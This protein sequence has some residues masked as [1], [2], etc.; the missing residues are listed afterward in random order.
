MTRKNNASLLI[1]VLSMAC[2][3]CASQPAASSAKA[4]KTA[5][6]APLW[7]TDTQ[8][9]YPDKVWLCAVQQGKDPGGAQSAAIAEL[10]RIFRVDVQAV[11]QAN[12]DIA[13][14]ATSASDSDPTLDLSE[15]RAY[16]QQV[17]SQSNI[18]GL[19]GLQT[20]FWKAADGTV[21]GC[22]YMNR[23][24][25]SAR[26][27]ALQHEDE[28]LI[29]SLSARAA[30]KPATIAAY[31][32]LQAAAEIGAAADNLRLMVSVLNPATA[33]GKAPYGGAA[34]LR[35]QA[36]SAAAA[37]VIAVN[38]AGNADTGAAA[39]VAVA[40]KAL[41]SGK[42]FRT[43]EAGQVKNAGYTLA[44]NYDLNDVDMGTGSD[45]K[46][47][48][49]RYEL[50]AVLKD[51]TGAELFSAQSSGREGQLT[52]AQAGERATRSAVDAISKG[53]FAKSFTTWLAQLSNSQ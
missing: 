37:V 4:A 24:E 2:V 27:A 30:A 45:Q 11:S 38:M 13:Q 10:S 31:S 20:D 49:V 23:T 25:C 34:A 9:A 46:Y 19:V 14:Y 47:K 1:L 43:A 35:T 15:N 33:G 36:K 39:K 12:E 26:Y 41:L 7:V 44:V 53:D 50:Q 42:G 29:A 17:N 3:G 22:A 18:S 16:A 8:A 32:D 40:L 48:F 51:K 52:T 6:T 21:W 28:A 5:D